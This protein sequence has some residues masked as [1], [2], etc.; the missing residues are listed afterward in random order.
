MARASR[1]APY[2]RMSQN[3]GEDHD[4]RVLTLS[5]CARQAEDG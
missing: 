5:G 2:A 1:L 3:G 4:L